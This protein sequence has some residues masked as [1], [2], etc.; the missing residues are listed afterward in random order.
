[1]QSLFKLKCLDISWNILTSYHDDLGP[2]RKHCPVLQILDTQHN[3]W[4]KVMARCRTLSRHFVVTAYSA[5]VLKDLCPWKNQ[6]PTKSGWNSSDRR[7]SFYSYSQCGCIT[8]D[9]LN[10]AYTCPHGCVP[11]P[12]SECQPYCPDAA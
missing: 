10:S 1:M 6:V 11:S 7:G 2:L 3:P 8:F 5:K 12:K 9:S 4:K